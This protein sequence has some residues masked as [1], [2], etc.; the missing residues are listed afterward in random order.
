MID[1][2][3]GALKGVYHEL[4]IWE[5]WGKVEDFG[6]IGTGSRHACTA[7]INVKYPYKVNIVE[8]KHIIGIMLEIFVFL[9]VIYMGW[10]MS[11]W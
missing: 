7:G 8:I 9:G 3:V 2:I 11:C 6:C 4:N 5:P 10:L 1:L